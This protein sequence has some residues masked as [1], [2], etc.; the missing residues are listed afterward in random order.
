MQP[1]L[2]MSKFC[3]MGLCFNYWRREENL[4]QSDI[5]RSNDRFC[6]INQERLWLPMTTVWLFSQLALQTKAWGGVWK[7]GP[8]LIRKLL[9]GTNLFTP[10]SVNVNYTVLHLK[11]FYLCPIHVNCQQQNPNIN[12]NSSK[13]VA[14]VFESFSNAQLVIAC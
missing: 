9:R 8:K 3:S 4:L 5:S 13:F 14:R 6:P 2:C 7:L 1:L 12:S 10:R 11:P